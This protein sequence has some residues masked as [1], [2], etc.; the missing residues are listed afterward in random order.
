M[1]VVGD[2]GG[3]D[4]RLEAR[5]H[6]RAGS[7]S[8]RSWISAIDRNSGRLRSRLAN[9]LIET[10]DF[11]KEGAIT[12]RER[13]E[14]DRSA[15]VAE[16]VLRL[17]WLPPS[18][19]SLTVL[20]RPPLPVVWSTVRDD[21]GAVLLLLR[22]P[23][24]DSSRPSFLTRMQDPA[25][26]DE[27]VRLLDSPG[28]EAVDWDAPAVRPIYQTALS[29]ATLARDYAVKTVGCDPDEAWAC[30]L[31]APLGWLGVCA[32]VPAAAAAC[33]A[34]PEFARR[35]ARTQRRHWSLD[36]SALAR[37]LAR[38]WRLPEWLR[39]VIGCLHLPAELARTFGPD[40]A[41]LRCVRHAVEQT[42]DVGLA[43][44]LNDGPTKACCSAIQRD[45]PVKVWR[46]PY[47]TPLLRDL[48]VLGAE[49]RRLSEV[50]HS[51]FLEREIDELHQ[52][53]EEQ[54]SAEDARLRAGKLA[55]LAEFAAG[56][57][58]EINNPLA[59]ISGQA[60]YLLAHAN[61][62]FPGESERP[63]KALHTIIGQTHR[64]HGLL[65]NLMLFARPATPRPVWF[66]LPSLLAETASSLGELAEPRGVRIEVGRN[67][68]R[69]AVFADVE[70]VRI[71]LTCL[72]RNAIEAAPA[73]SWARVGVVEPVSDTVIEVAVEDG[74]SGPDPAQRPALF[75]PF[76][77]GRAAGRGLG[78]G[79]PVAWRLTRQQGGDVRLDTT[80]P[81]GPTRF[82][83]SLPRIPP[84]EAERAA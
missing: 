83:L 80:R 56:A 50:A 6:W 1:R 53:V 31:L 75:D 81:G 66:D 9:E 19:A 14:P 3:R 7:V 15:S 39:T 45:E 42:R 55:A 72:I 82:I 61:D 49:N 57:G 73:E 27:A 4:A 68:D 34:D 58:H 65:R 69:L 18:A 29:L 59:V 44:G 37:R 21:P 35:P 78:L 5:T 74:G 23:S 63:R 16:A 77:S 24:S 25:F 38:R 52:A 62:W 36:Q 10:T 60:Q 84:L 76:Y 51:T 28:E 40:L 46:S 11:S 20:A 47:Q 54:T 26:L 33:L 8:D 12:V 70:Q 79:L 41:L 2:G 32:A 43:L 64:I 30:G 48:L 22:R 17:V 13:A 71:A 67:P